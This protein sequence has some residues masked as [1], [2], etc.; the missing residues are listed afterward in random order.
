MSSR[1]AR[2]FGTLLSVLLL[3]AYFWPGSASGE[4]A[5]SF[6][7]QAITMIIG[8]A[9][10]GGTDAS[11]RII[12]SF[13]ARYLP[14]EP[15]VIVRNVPGAEGITAMNY[16]VQQV[17]PD[18]LTI[19]MGAASVADPMNFRK[20]N[21]HYDPATFRLI[22][23][24]GRGG[25]VLVV[26]KDAVA[27]LQDRSAAPVIM[28]SNEAMPRNGMQMTV[29]G[30]AFL[31]WQARWVSGYPG[32][33]EVMLALERGEIDMTATSNMFQLQKLLEGG[34]TR[35]LYQ[36]GSFEEGK[37]TGRLD[38]GSLPLFSDALA[39]KISE[40]LA[41]QAFKYWETLCS[42]D[43]WVALPPG[44]P[45]DI[46][47]V[48]RAA[49]VKAAA[50]PAFIAQGKKISDDFTPQSSTD[51]D[52]LMKTLVQTSAEATDYTKGLMRA[53]GLHVE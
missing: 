50:D 49:F 37:M 39:G 16:V 4:D 23:G 17:K 53:Q 6:K 47:D 42:M 18:G 15:S 26:A 5:R 10:G 29:W 30:I 45:D 20:A 43:K 12:A 19:I 52:L 9:P 41:A 40:P 32:T 35:T 38:L 36:T 48:Y 8:S 25:S 34:K 1:T 7:G 24:V 2:H 44:T 31:G 51:V 11:G 33:N 14:G 13:L 3:L 22:G 46:H 21:A 27:R 28:G